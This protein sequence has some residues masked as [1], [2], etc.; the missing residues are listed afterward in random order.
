MEAP[1]EQRRQLQQAL[2]PEAI[3]QAHRRAEILAAGR[4]EILAYERDRSRRF[5]EAAAWRRDNPGCYPT[6]NTAAP[7]R[8][9][10]TAKVLKRVRQETAAFRLPAEDDPGVQARLR[11]M[12]G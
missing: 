6:A 5:E 8:E 12:G 3:E 10:V 4:A 1:V 11:E 9:P 2:T 7:E